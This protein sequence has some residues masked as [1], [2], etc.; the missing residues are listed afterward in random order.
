MR[1][2]CAVLSIL[3]LAGCSVPRVDTSSPQRAQESFK[4]VR[5]SLAKEKQAKFDDAVTIIAMSKVLEGGFGSMIARGSSGKPPEEMAAEALA[6]LN[7]KTGE[8]II[9][10][11]EQLVA[12]RKQKEREQALKEVQELEQKRANAQAAESQLAKFEVVTSRFRK[13]KQNEF[14]PPQPI[15][16]LAVKNGTGKAIKR[17]YFVGTLAS[18]GR[19]VPWMKDDF[20]YEI[21]GGLEAGESAEWH[22][23]PNMFSHWGRVEA[24]SD[25]VLTVQPVKLEGANNEVLYDAAFSEEDQKRLESLKKSLE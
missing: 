19:T 12:A 16:E 5:D 6:P 24:P 23:S 13:V 18:P 21:S 3:A 17:A 2:A 20:N 25:A 8:E 7:G 22:L 15:I 10:Q 11:A 4:R 9:T 14:L 1:L